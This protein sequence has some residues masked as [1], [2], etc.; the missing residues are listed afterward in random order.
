[1]VVGNAITGCVF[2]FRIAAMRAFDCASARGN[3]SA[4]ANNGDSAE[5]AVI[6]Q[7][8]RVSEVVCL[9]HE[10]RALLQ[11]PPLVPALKSFADTP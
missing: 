1:M 9:A 7:S 5:L 11:S 2:A 3:A 10:R 4:R 8:A 6:S